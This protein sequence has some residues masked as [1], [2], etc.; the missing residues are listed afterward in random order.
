[1]LKFNKRILSVLFSLIA[2][3]AIS[4][5]G[6]S[7]AQA[8]DQDEHQVI[9]GGKTQTNDPTRHD[10]V[11]PG[12]DEST[13]ISPRSAIGYQPITGF[14]F[15]FRGNSYKVSTSELKHGINGNGLKINSEYA[16]YRAPS[17][18][19]NWRVDYQN[20]YGGTIYSTRKG[21]VHSGCDFG[22]MY[23]V[24]PK[25]FSV[26]KGSQCAR[27]YVAGSYRGEQCHNVG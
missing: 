6:A 23:D 26:K 20:R 22:A 2:C 8:E 10:Y 17:T 3:S 9:Y 11:D 15:N 7:V 1:M 21:G 18:V 19:C 27:L 5:S 13:G 25:N 24:G 16:E 4:L 12:D 14:S